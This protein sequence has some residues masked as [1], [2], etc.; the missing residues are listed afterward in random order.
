MIIFLA[1]KRF[2]LQHHKTYR[3]VSLGKGKN[4]SRTVFQKA[5]ELSYQRGYL[6]YGLG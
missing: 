1:L 5:F 3:M 4:T 6:K 2:D